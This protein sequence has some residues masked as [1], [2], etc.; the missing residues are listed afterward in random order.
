LLKISLVIITKN[1]EKYLEG[2][3]RSA[4]FADEIVVVDSGSEDRTCD[5]AK[6]LGARVFQEPWRG[7]GPQKQR[8]VELASHSWILS[9]DADE[10]LSPALAEEIQRYLKTEPNVDGF[11]M[12]RLSF[13][14]G[15]WIRHGGW[16]PDR[17]LRVFHRERARWSQARIHER[18]QAQK[19]Q[20]LQHPIE[21]FVFENLADQVHTNN[22]YSGLMA[23]DLF[24]RHIRFS[25]LRLLI[26]P[27]SKFFETYLWKRGFMDGLP[28]FIISVGAAYSVFLKFAKLWELE[29]AFRNSQNQ[30]ISSSHESNC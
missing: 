16:Y 20:L 10:R 28:G 21:H 11:E 25:I 9:L 23:Q 17:Q 22:R 2:C 6:S 14:M 19:T 27:W 18:V 8:A 3:I 7:F 30:P 5:I 24:D 13:H 26:K 12:P 1:E 4:L 29:R 15:R